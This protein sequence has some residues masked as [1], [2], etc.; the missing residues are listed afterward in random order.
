MPQNPIRWFE[1]YVE[2]MTRAKKFYE[3]VFQ[4]T[5]EKIPG[6]EGAGD[7]TTEMWQFPMNNDQ[8]GASGT[9]VKMDGLKPSGVGTVV[10]FG[11]DDCAVEEARIIPAGGKI[12]K[13]KTSIGQ[14]GFISLGYDTEGNIFGIHSM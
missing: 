5:L 3:A 6:P 1:I 14:Y 4:C 9:L 7:F 10:Y 2:D 11:S 13:N 8:Y 12:H